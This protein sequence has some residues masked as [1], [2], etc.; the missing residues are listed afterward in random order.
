MDLPAVHRTE[1][2][3]PFLPVLLGPS[4]SSSTLSHLA[5]VR[6]RRVGMGPT[7]IETGADLGHQGLAHIPISTSVSGVSIPASF[8][9]YFHVC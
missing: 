6:G 3:P 1:G 5:A 7:G 8:W 4:I 2:D 9:R